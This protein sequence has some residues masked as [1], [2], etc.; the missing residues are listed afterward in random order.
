MIATGFEQKIDKD[1]VKIN[2]SDSN[3]I[4]DYI[5]KEKVAEDVDKKIE[6]LQTKIFNFDKTGN[7]EIENKDHIEFISFYNVEK[8]NSLF[9]NLDTISFKTLDFECPRKTCF[10]MCFLMISFLSIVFY[11]DD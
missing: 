7:V 11:Q 3:D 9:K 6:T 5:T 4:E 8:L 10:S 2:L 1:P